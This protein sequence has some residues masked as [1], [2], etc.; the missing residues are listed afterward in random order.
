MSPNSLR[1]AVAAVASQHFAVVGRRPHFGPLV[2]QGYPELVV[3]SLAPTALAGF[4]RW[5]SGYWQF[6]PFAGIFASA[7]ERV[8]AFGRLMLAAEY[9]SFD[10]LVDRLPSSLLALVL[11]RFVAWPE[12]ERLVAWLDGL[13]CSGLE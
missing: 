11:E 12:I 8:L 7:A 6:V 4:V 10:R 2:V 9:A 5:A 13:G 1:S 3:D